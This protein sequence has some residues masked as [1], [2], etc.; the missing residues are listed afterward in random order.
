[1]DVGAMGSAEM[2][3]ETDG[4]PVHENFAVASSFAT[5]TRSE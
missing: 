2:R 1:M 4:A 3:A 5:G